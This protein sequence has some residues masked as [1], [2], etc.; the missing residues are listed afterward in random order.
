MV[1]LKIM[2]FNMRNDYSPD[3]INV[4]SNR[5][6]KIEA[7]LAREQPDIVGVQECTDRMC[8]F[9]RAACPDYTFYGCGREADCHGEH[10]W[11]G[12]RNGLFSVLEMR[13]KWL[14]FT[15]D[16]SG[17]TFGMDQSKCSRMYTLLRLCHRDA[18]PFYVVNTH[19]DHVGV[20]A[21]EYAMAE[22]LQALDV[23]AAWV[24]MGDMNARP[25]A[26]AV[27]M[28]TAM[29]GRPVTDA[30]AGLGYTFHAFGKRNAENGSKI[31]YIFT[32]AACDPAKSYRVEDAPADGIYYSDHF[33]VCAFVTFP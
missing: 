19:L 26:D 4:F 9:L 8:D 31:D 12:L 22:I 2:T 1:T 18:A 23:P 5:Q 16:I 7:M 28:A 11:I 27:R 15:P 14:S 10:T 29:P 32:T 30:T 33:A 25:D 20:K 17:S 24:L 21:R 6:P 3:G 13:N